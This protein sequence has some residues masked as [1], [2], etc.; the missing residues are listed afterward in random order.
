MNQKI[1]EIIP[2]KSKIGPEFKKNAKAVMD[3]I[4]NADE[5]TLEKIINEGLETEYGVIRKEHIKDVKRAL[6]CEG[7]EV[8]SVDIEGVLAMAIIRK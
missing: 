1:V 5:E 4:K 6:F 7:E 2:D 3:L 8:D